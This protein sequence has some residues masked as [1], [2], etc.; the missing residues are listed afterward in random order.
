M[1]PLFLEYCAIIKRIIND[2]I[3]LSFVN[4][5]PQNL[6]TKP[7]ETFTKYDLTLMYRDIKTTEENGEL[8]FLDI[9]LKI[10]PCF[11]F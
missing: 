2:I 11:Q 5:A 8:E 3:V 10:S 4:Q 1:Q 9:L 7:L 6:K